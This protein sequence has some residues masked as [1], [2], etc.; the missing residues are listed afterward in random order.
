MVTGPQSLTQAERIQTIGNALGRSLQIEEMT[1]D[2]A[3]SGVAAGSGITDVHRHAAQGVGS[4]ARPA[5]VCELHLRAAHRSRITTFSRMGLGLRSGLSRVASPHGAI[6]APSIPSKSPSPVEPA[7]TGSAHL[8][9]SS[10]NVGGFPSESADSRSRV[11]V[12]RD[13]EA[14]VS[15]QGRPTHSCSLRRRVL[16]IGRP[17]QGEFSSPERRNQRIKEIR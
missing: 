8:T 1:P 3:R 7:G 9:L 12:P 4:S 5:G 2:E 15:D 13:R 10:P 11:T 6:S 16:H 17:R 14:N